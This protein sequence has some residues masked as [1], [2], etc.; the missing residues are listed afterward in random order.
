MNCI[1]E[2]MDEI[3]AI[4]V[5]KIKDSTI[6]VRN[7]EKVL[8]P[9]DDFFLKIYTYW[10]QLECLSKQMIY[11]MD[12]KEVHDCLCHGKRDTKKQKDLDEL[13]A[14]QSLVSEMI[15]IS[16]GKEFDV[17]SCMVRIGKGFKII[18]PKDKLNYFDVSMAELCESLEK[19]CSGKNKDSFIA[20]H[21]RAS[22]DN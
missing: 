11:K 1:E 4:E 18:I 14:V 2:L 5:D 10:S 8:G 12:N 19:E 13:A 15:R 21:P 22:R 16:L 6:P 9:A 20:I 3:N 17:W 7:F